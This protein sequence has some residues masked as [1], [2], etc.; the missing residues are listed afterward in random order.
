MEQ[1]FRESYRD[2]VRGSC[3]GRACLWLNVLTDVATTATH[4]NGPQPTAR[5]GRKHDAP[6]APR[7]LQAPTGSRSRAP[8]DVWPGVV[9]G[10]L[11]FLLMGL[12]QVLLKWPRSGHLHPYAD[13][14]SEAIGARIFLS[15]SLLLLAGVFSGLDQGLPPLVLHVRRLSPALLV[16]S[17]GHAPWAAPPHL[18]RGGGELPGR[19]AWLPLLTTLLLAMLPTRSPR[20]LLR[21]LAGV[22]AQP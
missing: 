12:A 2:A 8:A 5:R 1:V 4:T 16:L 10:V 3:P 17:D 9:A 11:P 14:M 19:R 20:P 7:A 18:A 13:L 22:S 6:R 15:G 21:L